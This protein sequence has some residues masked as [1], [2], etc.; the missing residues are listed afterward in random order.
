MNLEKEAR[1]VALKTAGATAATTLALMLVGA[2]ENGDAFTPINAVS[3]IP[4][5]E[6]AKKQRGFSA[7]WTLPG[8]ALSGF[9]MA[10]WALIHRA[11][12]LALPSRD[13]EK[14]A[15]TRTKKSRAAALGAA[16]SALAYIVDFKVV[17]PSLRPG[18]ETQISPRGL[19]FVYLVLA[20]SLAACGENGEA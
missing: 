15:S 11:G 7:R 1:Q 17:P 16:V 14:S 9:A 18:F 3:H 10:A 6:R 2:R 12:M 19:L 5:G 8:I 20:I 13:A 4:W